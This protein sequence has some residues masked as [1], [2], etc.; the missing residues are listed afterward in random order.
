MTL[1]RCRY[2]VYY[3]ICCKDLDSFD[4]RNVCSCYSI[5]VEFVKKSDDDIYSEDR[6]ENMILIE[7]E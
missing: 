4:N 3:P 1:E 5:K 7:E 2:C 6:I